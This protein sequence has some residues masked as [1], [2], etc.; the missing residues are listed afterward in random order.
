MREFEGLSPFSPPR[1]RCLP[2]LGFY[3][4]RWKTYIWHRVGVN[5]RLLTLSKP[6]YIMELKKQ[7]RI[8]WMLYGFPQNIP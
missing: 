8:V 6:W 3:G 7:T 2:N 4:F 5:P 1:P